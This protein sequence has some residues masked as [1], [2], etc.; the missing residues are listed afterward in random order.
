[1][2][3]D[4]KELLIESQKKGFVF[5]TKLLAEHKIT[6]EYKLKINILNVH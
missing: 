5:L 2:E 1:M 6:H 3:H 4:I